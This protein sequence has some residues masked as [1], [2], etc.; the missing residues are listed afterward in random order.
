[1]RVQGL[2]DVI[3][4]RVGRG[5]AC[6]VR[7]DRSVWC[8]GVSMFLGPN[9][10]PTSVPRRACCLR[11]PIRAIG[12]GS[13]WACALYMDGH[14][15][16]VTPLDHPIDQPNW[17][18]SQREGVDLASSTTSHVALFAD[19][20]VEG[21]TRHYRPFGQG[22]I[23]DGALGAYGIARGIEGATQVTA[24][25]DHACALLAT[26]EVRCWGGNSA[27][28][29]GDGTLTFRDAPVTVQGLD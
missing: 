5:Y 18:R 15:E 14:Y 3:S 22:P 7:G 1:M 20:T 10:L 19:G 29:L 13:P 25:Y 12:L 24:G 16:C 17:G 21:I 28:Q 9:E 23:Q 2:D 6:A 27:G 26:G 4:I 8:W 11:G